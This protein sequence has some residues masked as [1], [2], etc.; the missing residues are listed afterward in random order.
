MREYIFTG[1]LLKCIFISILLNCIF[2]CVLLN[3]LYPKNNIII[4]F[5]VYLLNV[6]QID[7][8][9]YNCK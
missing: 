2:I 8:Y 4:L 9:L 7:I 5:F 6:F 3:K 1:I